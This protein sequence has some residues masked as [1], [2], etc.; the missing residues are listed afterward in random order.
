MA[1]DDD[2]DHGEAA[3]LALRLVH[4]RGRKG[5]AD[6]GAVNDDRPRSP[7]PQYL[8]DMQKAD[9][10]LG[11]F[12]SAHPPDILGP[13][14][15]TAKFAGDLSGIPRAVSSVRE[16]IRDPSLVN[17]LVAGVNTAAAP[18]VAL[19]APRT[20]AA[21]IG[22]AYG[23]AGGKTA[24]DEGLLSLGS[25]AQGGQKAKPPATVLPGLT[26]EQQADL[27]KARK[28]ISDGNYDSSAARRMLEDTV[29][30]YMG[31]S[32]DFVRG[33][34]EVETE[35]G[36]SKQAA[37]DRAV[38]EAEAQRDYW[39]GLANKRFSK[40]PVGEL[41]DK[42]GGLAP[43]AAGLFPGALSR[44]VTGEAKPILYNYVLPGV[45]G[46]L[47]GM[48]A[49]GLP[50][51]Y[52]ALAGVKRAKGSV[53]RTHAMTA[54]NNEQKRLRDWSTAIGRVAMRLGDAQLLKS[55]AGIQDMASK[56]G[57][58]AAPSTQ[59]PQPLGSDNAQIGRRPD[60]GHDAT[61]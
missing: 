10:P 14:I 44:A 56:L 26:A 28:D 12:E 15:D 1:H 58:N 17:T 48:G 32:A 8:I 29:R 11:D 16:A 39:L 54:L 5:Y 23:L 19:R 20:A 53:G 27:D 7:V 59:A 37:Y 33:A 22:G 25:P 43:F 13:F 45:E 21:I 49:A 57:T 2:D 3:H 51:A 35:A 61:P 42:T 30:N 4:H 31:I 47:A 6:A 9:R 24:Y 41:Y 52:N 46:V 36:K 60:G 18:L 55:A 50:L 40:T 34:A 38:R